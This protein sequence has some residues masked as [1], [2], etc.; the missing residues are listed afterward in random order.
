[1]VELRKRKAPP[2]VPARPAKK[3]P[4][5]KGKAAQ[6]KEAVEEKVSNAV[7]AVKDA[8]GAN[9]AESE[10]QQAPAAP[11]RAGAPKVG[12]T[13][14]LEDFGG[15]VETHDGKKVTLKQLV[16]E[17]K[18]GVVLFTYPKASTPGCEFGL[19]SFSNSNSKGAQEN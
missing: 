13:I 12:D 6:A 8:V 4:G 3:K 17:S 1:M 19:P 7:D 9:G 2:P 15:E 11:P 5:P 16:E 14:A 18:D 10:P